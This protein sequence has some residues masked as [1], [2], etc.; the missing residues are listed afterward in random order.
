MLNDQ[1]RKRLLQ[2]VSTL[3]IK[4]DQV[5]SQLTFKPD[6]I[7]R[8]VLMELAAFTS[9]HGPINGAFIFQSLFPIYVVRCVLVPSV[10]YLFSGD[11]ATNCHKCRGLRNHRNL[12]SHNSGCQKSEI[13]VARLKSGSL[14]PSV[15]G[16]S[17]HSFT[18]GHIPPLSAPMVPKPFPLCA[19]F[20]LLSVSNLLLSLS[21]KNT[22]GGA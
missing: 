1:P 6:P 11:T 22:W 21:Y 12:C 18:C 9:I 3:G 2:R 19:S 13:N 8:C 17:E 15:P 10:I 14:L 7:V 4:V 16:G 20:S 5:I